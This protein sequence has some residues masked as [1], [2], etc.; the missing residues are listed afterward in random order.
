MPRIVLSIQ[1]HNCT[2][3][4]IHNSYAAIWENTVQLCGEF[5][6]GMLRKQHTVNH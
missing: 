2:I 1:L 4:V 5:T 3:R 6:Y